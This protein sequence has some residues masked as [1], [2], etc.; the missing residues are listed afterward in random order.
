MAHRKAGGTA[1]NLSYSNP[2]Y[3]GI[4]LFAGEKTKI[5][6]IIVRQRGTKFLP[7]KNVGIGRDHT[8]F[9][10]KIGVVEFKDKRKVRF[11][12]R[13]IIKKSVSVV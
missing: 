2:Q 6:D 10:K 13:K 7:G 8:I 5:G 3:L 1:R 4:K 11:D 12:G 9:A